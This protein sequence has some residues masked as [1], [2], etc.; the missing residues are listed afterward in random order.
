VSEVKL[1]ANG[2]VKVT[3]QSVKRKNMTLNLTDWFGKAITVSDDGPSH[4]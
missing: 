1:V 3:C 2:C 4:E